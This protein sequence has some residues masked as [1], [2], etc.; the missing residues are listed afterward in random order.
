[1]ILWDNLNGPRKKKTYCKHS[2]IVIFIE[3]TNNTD[4]H[5][6]HMVMILILEVLPYLKSHTRQTSPKAHHTF[7]ENTIYMLFIDNIFISKNI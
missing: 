2:K 3:R 7:Y 5:N 1:M 6:R 4:K